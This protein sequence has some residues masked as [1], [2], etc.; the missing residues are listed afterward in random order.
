MREFSDNPPLPERTAHFVPRLATLTSALLLGACAQAGQFSTSLPAGDEAYKIVPAP[1]ADEA[2][3]YKVG[4]LDTLSVTVFQEPDLTIPQIQVDAAGNVLF[5]LIGT[6]KA[7]GKSAHELSQEISDRLDQHYLRNAQVS[8]VV[9]ASASQHITVE[10]NVNQPGVYDI[11]GT[12]S[13]LE[14]VARAKSPTRVARLDQVV[15]FRLVNGQRMGAVFDLRKIR[16]GRSPDP[17]LLGGDVVVVGFSA[18]KGAFRDF[19]T[20]APL[21]SVFRTY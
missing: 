5:P 17:Q 14:A 8:V 12:S 21:L 10:G 20:M 4:P 3:D 1:K 15:V 11:N 16:D 2:R 9:Q 18:V 6:V 19:L 7:A 13:L